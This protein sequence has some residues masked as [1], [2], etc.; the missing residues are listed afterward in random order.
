[1]IDLL[2]S[3]QFATPLAPWVWV[4]VGGV[5]ALSLV[6]Y[7]LL[8]RR[9]GVS[10]LGQRLAGCCLRLVGVSG[11]LAMLG[12]LA[13]HGSCAL[14]VA[15]AQHEMDCEGWRHRTQPRAAYC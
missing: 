9:L 2:R 12:G 15:S 7:G 4:M 14:H 10:S 5:V 1:M 13:I 6:E 11:L 8:A 3:L